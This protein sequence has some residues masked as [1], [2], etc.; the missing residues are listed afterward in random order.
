MKLLTV[1]GARPQFVKAATVSRVLREIPE[2][3]EILVHTGQHHDGNMSDIFFEQMDIPRPDYHLGVAGGGHGQMT[4]RMLE[5]LEILMLKENPDWVLVYGDTNSTLAGALAAVKLNLPL[6]HVEAGLRSYNLGMP[7]E[8]NRVMTDRVSKLLFCPTEQSVRNLEAEGFV[9]LGIEILKVGDVMFDATE[10]YRAKASE[11]AIPSDLDPG[12]PFILATIHRAEN[13]DDDMRLKKIV[14]GL[15]QVHQ[16]IPVLLSL[17]PRT[18]KKFSE[19]KIKP[20]FH[21][22]DPVGYLEMLWLL[23]RC[24]LVVTDSGGLQKEACFYRKGCITLRQETEW[25]E[26]VE[27]GVNR[28][29]DVAAA[30]IFPAIKEMLNQDMNFETD[31]YG[32]GKASFRIVQ[33]LLAQDNS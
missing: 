1:I 14:K 30:E 25:T 21:T 18:R 22:I 16:Q 4:G 11:P 20:G 9:T 24:N 15:E 26:L 32:D 33:R 6:A 3:S 13:T 28:L 29:V 10:F 2:V 12:R 31:L 19:M 7:E 17:H 8:V 23:E 5:Q 27:T